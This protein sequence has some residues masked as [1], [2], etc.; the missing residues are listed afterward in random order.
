[1]NHVDAHL[2]EIN[3]LKRELEAIAADNEELRATKTR[4][5]ELIKA[6]RKESYSI[7]M[8]NFK[9]DETLDA[10]M[11][12]YYRISDQLKKLLNP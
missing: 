12:E 9:I 11:I 6:L 1:M 5:V 8:R 4:Q 7:K 10:N 2:D 3:A